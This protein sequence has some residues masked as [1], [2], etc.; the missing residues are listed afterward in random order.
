M[1]ARL[2]LC[3]LTLTSACS[4]DDA[5]F[6]ES[7][8]FTACGGDVVGTWVD[9]RGCPPMVWTDSQPYADD[10]ACADSRWTETTTRTDLVYVFDAGGGLAQHL[11]T[12][13][14]HDLGLSAACV[15]AASGGAQTLAAA[16]DQAGRDSGLPCAVSGELCTCHGE[17]NYLT[18]LN[19]TYAASGTTI[20][21]DGVDSVEYCVAGDTLA[22]AAPDGVGGWATVIFERQR[23]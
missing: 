7:F 19:G 18:D 17:I 10:P 21:L 5:G 1:P 13:S 22:L 4:G 15:A 3:C 16:C 11:F 12:N 8:T 9:P 6:C 23:L 20:V 2:L 14:A